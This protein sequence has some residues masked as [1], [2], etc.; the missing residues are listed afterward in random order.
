M[1][2]TIVRLMIRTIRVFRYLFCA[3][4]Q[5]GVRRV[6]RQRQGHE[7]TAKLRINRSAKAYLTSEF[8]DILA[9][10]ADY[11]TGNLQHRHALIRISLG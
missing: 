8:R 3:C 11:R 7:T 2:F 6:D 1:T 4:S 5:Q 9:T 10:L